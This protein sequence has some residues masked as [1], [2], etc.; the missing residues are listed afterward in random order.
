MKNL[1]RM[2]NMMKVYYS[3]SL[4]KFEKSKV[5]PKSEFS[6]L[7][8]IFCSKVIGGAKVCPQETV[9]SIQYIHCI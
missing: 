3:L 8:P 6:E 5:K 4:M 9:Q 7:M 1:I 2:N